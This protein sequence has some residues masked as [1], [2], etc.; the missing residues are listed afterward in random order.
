MLQKVCVCVR[1]FML[2]SAPEDLPG[3]RAAL[4][5]LGAGRVTVFATNEEFEDSSLSLASD[6]SG[7]ENDNR[8]IL[9]RLFDWLAWLEI[10]Q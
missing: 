6:Q 1:F 10:K 5:K 4:G 9:V 7:K 8:E 3:Y 2:V